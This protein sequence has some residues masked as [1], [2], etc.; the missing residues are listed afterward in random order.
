MYNYRME[1][2]VWEVK[3]LSWDD[4][5]DEDFY[6]ETA[7]P[8]SLGVPDEFKKQDWKVLYYLNRRIGYAIL[9]QYYGQ[10]IYYGKWPFKLKDSKK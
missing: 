8:I 3:T 10:Y 5:K 2:P 1:T 6:S 7:Y 4:I 9:S